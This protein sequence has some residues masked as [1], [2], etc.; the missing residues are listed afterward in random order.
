MFLRYL[1][2]TRKTIGFQLT[3]WYCAIFILSSLIFF[4]LIYFFLSLSLQQ[5][6]REVIQAELE[7]YL[8][9]YQK[10][11]TDAL[12][13]EMEENKKEMEENK[14]KKGVSGEDYFFVR[15]AG[16]GNNTV[17]L[18]IPEEQA[19]FDLKQFENRVTKGNRRWS[20]FSAKNDKVIY[21]ILSYRLANDYLLQVG[22]TITKRKEFLERFRAIFAAIIIPVI[23]FGFTGGAFLSFRA[24]RPIR[25]LINTIRL[26]I[27]TGKME[28][29]MPTGK[30]GDELDELSKLFN[31]MLEKI[32]NL[33]KG[34]REG[35]DNVAHDLRTPVTRL[36]GIA[37]IA[38]Q[39]EQ[40]I[41]ILRETLSD[42]LE[43]TERIL[44][45]LNTLMDISEAETGAMKL[46]LEEVNVAN[47]IEEVVD[48]YNYVAEEKNISIH[49]TFP[50][51][52]YLTA[53]HNRL[54]QVIANLLDNAIKYTHS[55][56]RIDIEAFQKQQEI[57]ITIKD[58]GIGIPA[59][60]LSRIWE[61]LYRVDR[62][63]SQR[64]LGLGLTLVKAIVQ[65][66]KGYIEVS[67][68]PAAGSLFVI[69]FPKK[70]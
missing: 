19:K 54:R 66:H 28:A 36:K 1:D 56:G 65:A 63:R 2:R 25:Y 30:R 38:L 42:C 69:Y 48:L 26:I 29:R 47:L 5:R 46:N 52:L 18:Y 51:E 22:K 40:N 55:N 14:F 44:T 9:K 59:E 70:L 20:F 62:S 49:A 61:R 67:S 15:L 23:F 33:I 3:L 6:D 60:E 39:S 17:F 64:G 43:E 35:L 10:G 34:M 50:K 11:G 57:V 8:T 45:M 27:D 53:D 12:L 24:L 41:N 4:V 16:P 7:D 13:K 31:T 58:T 37:E 21:E 32:E 68:E